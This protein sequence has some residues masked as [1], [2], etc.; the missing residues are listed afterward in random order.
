VAWLP[1]NFHFLPPSARWL[2]PGAI[3][4]PRIFIWIGATTRENLAEEASPLRLREE[5][6]ALE[7]DYRLG[8]AAG[9]SETLGKER[10]ASALARYLWPV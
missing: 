10:V 8:P 1:V 9:D 3:G 4:V 5:G 6:A 7:Q 2:R